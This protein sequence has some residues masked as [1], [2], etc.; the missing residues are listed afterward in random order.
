[1]GIGFVFVDLMD[2]LST[3]GAVRA[4]GWKTKGLGVI[5][6]PGS[7]VIGFAVTEL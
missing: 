6:V 7:N 3:A 2:D 5:A 1:M 4:R